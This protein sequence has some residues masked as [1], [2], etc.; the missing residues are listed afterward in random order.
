MGRLK[1]YANRVRCKKCGEVIESRS[2][3][4]FKQCR[5]GAVYTDGGL[6]YIR[7]G[8]DPDQMEDYSLTTEGKK[9]GAYPSEYWY[10]FK[11]VHT[12]EYKV[13][14][15]PGKNDCHPFT[16][17]SGDP[18]LMVKIES[19]DRDAMPRAV[20]LK[21]IIL[22]SIRCEGGKYHE[23][24][25]ENWKMEKQ[26]KDD[27]R[28][29]PTC[30]Y[31]ARIRIWGADDESYTATK[32]CPEECLSMLDNMRDIAAEGRSL[33]DYLIDNMVYTN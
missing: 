23:T 28:V 8:G 2:V 24:K 25:K 9:F 26:F 3:H 4:D 20:E 29:Y 22:D 32:S 13:K 33:W 17:G 11:P 7:R 1:I 16:D 10:D 30:H 27:I 14:L 18:Y 19:Y 31:P 21:S 12:W 5:C 6:D 15:K